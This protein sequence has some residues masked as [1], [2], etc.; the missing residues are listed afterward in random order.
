MSRSIVFLERD[1]IAPDVVVRRPSFAHTWKDYDRTT[2]EQLVERLK[3]AQIAVVNKVR[4]QRPAIEVL[5]K[6]KLIAVAATGTDNKIGR[7]HV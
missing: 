6:L 3:D 4:F 7:A 2:P 5:S 1:T